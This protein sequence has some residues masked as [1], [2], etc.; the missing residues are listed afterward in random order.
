MVIQ[1]TL[2]VFLFLFLSSKVRNIDVP[3]GGLDWVGCMTSTPIDIIGSGWFDK[4][5]APAPAYI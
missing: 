3:Y 5:A 1:C 2:S 4:N